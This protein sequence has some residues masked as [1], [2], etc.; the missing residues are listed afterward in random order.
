MDPHSAEEGGILLGMDTRKFVWAGLVLG[1]LIGSFI[2]ELWG[3]GMFSVSALL[4]SAA[5]AVGGIWL[6]YRLSQ[7]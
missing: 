3:A 6:G 4:L 5:G 1:S 7:L 2:P